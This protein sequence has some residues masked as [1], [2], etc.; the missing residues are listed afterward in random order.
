[1]TQIITKKAHILKEFRKVWKFFWIY[2]FDRTIVK[3]AGRSRS[4]ILR[5]FF[6]KIFF[7]KRLKEISL[8]GC[9]QF[10]FSTISYFLLK[11]MGNRFLECYDLNK[12]NEITTA[13]F[14]GYK[15]GISPDSLL[16][17]PSCRF[18]YIASNHSTHAD[19]AVKALKNNKTVYIEKPIAVNY[20]Q[21]FALL[22]AKE[23]QDGEVYVGYNRPF[24]KAIKHLRK[25]QPSKQPFTLNCFVIGH[26]IGKNHWYRN[27]EEGTRICGNMGHWIDLSLHLMAARNFIPE[28]FEISI[29]FCN[30]E[31]PDDN[32]NV[33]IVTEYGDL[34]TILLSAREEPFEG[35]NETINFQ[36]EHLI[37]K[38][39]DFRKMQIW[40][41]SKHKSYSYRPKDVGHFK[42]I[43]QPFDE[44]KRNFEEVIISTILMLEITDMVQKGETQRIVQPNEIKQQLLQQG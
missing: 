19:Y 32:I 25:L 42:A 27:P 9:G 36:S 18:I 8:I 35:I 1:M 22:L 28:R 20:Q 33:C 39:D 23:N 7:G 29:A 24:S 14:W 38:I 17:N 37:A 6:P 26:Q 40:K 13:N 30:K 41:G 43:N 44:E 21:L 11:K 16:S 5:V 34:I 3:V 2:G 15:S 10:G 4:S 31:E 12:E